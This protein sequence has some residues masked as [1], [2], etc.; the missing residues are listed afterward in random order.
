MSEYLRMLESISDYF[1]ENVRMSDRVLGKLLES[2]PD[3]LSD[4][5]SEYGTKCWQKCRNV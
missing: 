1:S 5:M 2:M 4:T 3:R